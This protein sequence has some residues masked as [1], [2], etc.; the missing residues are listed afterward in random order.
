MAQ[1]SIDES[2]LVLDHAGP[3]LLGSRCVACGAHTFPA[4]DGCARCTGSEMEPVRLATH[5]TLWTWTVQG[6]PPKAP[7][8][9][10]P[11]DP[12]EPFAVGY[13]ELPGQVRVEARLTESDPERLAI[14]M[15]MHLVTVPLTVDDAGDD[16]VTFAFAPVGGAS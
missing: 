14:G 5:G 9:V 11:T 12:F 13:V 7:P 1:V 4:Q 10:G 3:S 2:V 8:Y 16:V 6:F 15:S